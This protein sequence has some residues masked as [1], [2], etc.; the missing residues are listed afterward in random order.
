MSAVNRPSGPL[1]W[2]FLAIHVLKNR[3]TFSTTII[4]LTGLGRFYHV[5]IY[6]LMGLMVLLYT[7]EPV[8]YAD[9]LL[10]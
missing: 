6:I 3:L 4:L 8:L 7:A 2:L 1:V 10:C 5:V 9:T